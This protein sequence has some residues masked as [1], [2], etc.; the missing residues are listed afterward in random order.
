M[1]TPS[2]KIKLRIR[3]SQKENEVIEGKKAL[4]GEWAGAIRETGKG[5]SAHLA[6]Q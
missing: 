5:S 3:L 1:F 4:G 6:Q 2:N